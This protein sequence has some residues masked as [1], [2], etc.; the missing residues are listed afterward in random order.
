MLR[1]LKILSRCSAVTVPLLSLQTIF[2]FAAPARAQ[3]P[4][5]QNPS[6][7]T[8]E[9]DGTLRVRLPVVTVRAEK[10]PGNLQQSPVSV[11]AVTRDMLASSG[12]L[13]V[14]E[15]AQ[16]APNTYFTEFTARKLSNARFR[17]VGSSPNNPGVT[18]FIDGVPQL[19]AN[20][21]SIEL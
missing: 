12:A 16:Y 17:G 6:S 11:T 8:Q 2:W 10:E 7:V 3:E 20:S 21:S 18:T 13:T 14:S 1:P 4:P 19:N 5:A 15:A 9:D